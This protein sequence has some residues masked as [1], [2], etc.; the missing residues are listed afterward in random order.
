MRMIPGR[1]LAAAASGQGAAELGDLPE[2]NLADLYPGCGGKG[3][4]GRAALKVQVQWDLL[5][6][7]LA[8]AALESG[9]QP[10]ATSPSVAA[11]MWV[12]A[13]AGLTLW[14]VK[15]PRSSS[16]RRALS[17]RARSVLNQRALSP[18]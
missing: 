16:S 5:H 13:I 3:S 14:P 17:I 9:R 4:A 12:A 8:H 11:A 7:T 1:Q 6:G 18:R 10:D 15:S 2:W